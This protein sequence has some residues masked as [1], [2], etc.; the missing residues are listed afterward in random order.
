M[1][2]AVIGI[3][4]G[5][6]KIA[7]HISDGTL[8]SVAAL[9]RPTPA[10]SQPGALIGIEHDTSAHD[11]AL[12][13]GSTALLDALIQVCRDLMAQSAAHDVQIVAVGI[14]SAGQIDPNEGVVVDANENLVGWKGTPVAITLQTALGLPVYVENDVRTMILA[15]TTLGAGCTYRNVLGIAIGTGIGG[16]IVLDGRIWHG[17]HYSAGEIGYLY[18]APGQTIEDLYAGP[19][20]ARRYCRDHAPDQSLTL[21]E[22]A[23]RAHAGHLM[24]A[25]AIQTAAAELGAMLAPVFGLI[26]PEAVVI[27]G[28]VPEI[29]DLWWKPFTDAIR[30]CRLMSVQQMPVLRAEL[31]ADAGRI[32]AARL[33]AQKVGLL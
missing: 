11:E 16:A 10:E 21:V 25:D 15:E 27:G 32:G 29:G 18:A 6:T 30:A 5:G 4:I 2:R 17:A 7:A 3:D 9:K 33:A 13:R 22:I 26:D 14:G 23:N 31:G 28:G 1:K 19:A 12:R 20:I 8:W 24:C